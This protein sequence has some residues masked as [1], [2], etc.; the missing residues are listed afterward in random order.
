MWPVIKAA[1][2]L[3]FKREEGGA[4]FFLKRRG[5]LVCRVNDFCPVP[6]ERIQMLPEDVNRGSPFGQ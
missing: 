4:S 2:G 3:Q 5:V 6:G 1:I